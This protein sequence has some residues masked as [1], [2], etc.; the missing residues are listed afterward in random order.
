MQPL[1]RNGGTPGPA[2]PQ[3]AD[4]NDPIPGVDVIVKKNP[5]GNAFQ[6][7]TDGTGSFTLGGITTG[8]Y[9][10]DLPGSS[11]LPAIAKLDAKQFAGNGGNG[12]IL[13]G[14][15][16]AGGNGMQ[17]GGNN[18][19]QGQPGI[20]AV[21]IALLVPDVRQAAPAVT[22]DAWTTKDPGTGTGSKLVEHRFAKESLRSGI[23]LS[24]TVQKDGTAISWDFGDGTTSA[25]VARDGKPAESLAESSSPIPRDRIFS[26]RVT[27]VK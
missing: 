11:L 1:P 18:G 8:N 2:K 16:G 15:G 12:G 17:Q 19:N 23:H 4:S 24:F 6:I 27:A 26:G 21:L 3:P 10:I 13:W 20:I 9:E 25:N 22:K 7:K 5:G 14:N